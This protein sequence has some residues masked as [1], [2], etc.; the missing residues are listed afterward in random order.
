MNLAQDVSITKPSKP[1]SSDQTDLKSQ[2][3]KFIYCWL[4]DIMANKYQRQ[5]SLAG[6]EKSC[7]VMR[8]YEPFLSYLFGFHNEKSDVA[9]AAHTKQPVLKPL[10]GAGV[11]WGWQR[12]QGLGTLPGDSQPCPSQVCGVT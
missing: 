6:D 9:V 1:I 3:R 4:L 8:G 7:L 11:S 5:E 12:D 2:W 10:L